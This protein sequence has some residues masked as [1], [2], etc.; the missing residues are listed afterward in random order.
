MRDVDRGR[1][2]PIVQRT[3]LAAHDVAELGIERAERLVH[4]EGVRPPHDRAAE[5]D[6]LAV[7]AGEAGDRLVEQVV[8]TQDA[9]GLLDAA[10]DLAPGLPSH[11]SGKAILARTFMCG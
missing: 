5:R 2:E 3:Q 8:D 4:H 6:P 9:G 11:L 10:P 7:A 1:A